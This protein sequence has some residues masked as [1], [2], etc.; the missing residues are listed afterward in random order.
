[1]TFIEKKDEL[2]KEIITIE[3]VKQRLRINYSYG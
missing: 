3:E 1:M 2:M